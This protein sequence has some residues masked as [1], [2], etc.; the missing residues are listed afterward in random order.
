MRVARSMPSAVSRPVR[1]T[2]AVLAVALLGWPAVARAQIPHQ[3]T[4]S[5]SGVV[6]DST[7]GVLPG[8]RI[9]V[10]DA[11]GAVVQPVTTDAAGTFHADGLTPARYRLRAGF[12]GFQTTTVTVTLDGRNP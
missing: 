3:P 2:F 5:I 11:A 12:P 6:V 4:R 7:G 9:D 1:H 8:A 10:L